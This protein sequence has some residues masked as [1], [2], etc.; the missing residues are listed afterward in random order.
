MLGD[1]ALYGAATGAGAAP[2][3]PGGAGGVGAPLPL[4]RAVVL[5]IDRSDASRRQLK[6]HCEVLA[7]LRKRAPNAEYIE[8]RGSEVSLREQIKAFARAD[9]VVGPHGAAL[10]LVGFMKPGG[11][12]I[13]VAYRHKTWPAV[14][15]PVALGAGQCHVLFLYAC[16]VSDAMFTVGSR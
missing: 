16:P 1:V 14:F 12:V 2:A 4:K 8:F 11:A 5:L 7:R 3:D 9:F 6:N 13:E 10:G 15:M